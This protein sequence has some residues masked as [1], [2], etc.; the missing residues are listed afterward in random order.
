MY[1][2]EY[3]KTMTSTTI[4]VSETT[5]RELLRVAALLQ[6]KRG[7]KVDYDA[8]I[9]YLLK[10][11]RR[12]PELLRRAMAGAG[13]SVEELRRVMREGRTE[14]RKHEEYLESRYLI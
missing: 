12:N 1:P 8:A 4:T 6:S 14:D 13:V 7:E 10:K 11:S 9:E 5:R 3:M 2:M